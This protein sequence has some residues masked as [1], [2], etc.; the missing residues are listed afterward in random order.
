MILNASEPIKS[1][2]FW[3]CA[4]KLDTVEHSD[5]GVD[6]LRRLVD[7]GCEFNLP[8]YPFGVEDEDVSAFIHDIERTLFQLSGERLRRLA[9]I[10]D[11]GNDSE[12]RKI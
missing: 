7:Y 12:R 6:F 8:S 10:E 4:A 1:E 9:G 2:L 11:S 3:R 5:A